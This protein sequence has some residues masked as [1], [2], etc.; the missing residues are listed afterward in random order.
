MKSK[1]VKMKYLPT[2][3]QKETYTLLTAR[4]RYMKKLMRQ[5]VAAPWSSTTTGSARAQHELFELLERV[6][7]SRLDDQRAVLPPYF[8]Q[9]SR[10]E[11]RR[12]VSVGATTGSNVGER[13]SYAEGRVPAPH[14]PPPS[15]GAAAV[16]RRVAAAC[17]ASRLLLEETLAKP[18]TPPTI[19]QPPNGG[20]WVDGVEENSSDEESEQRP[21]PGT[22]RQNS[23]RHNIDTDDTA[24]YYRRFFLGKEHLNLVGCDANLGPVVMSLKNEHVAGQDHTRI[25]LRLRTETM[26]G[27]IPTP[28]SGIMPSPLRMAKMLNDQVN[29]ENF[30]AVM[31]LNAS[32]LIATYDEHVLVNTF[33][34]G[35]LYQKYGQ[36]TEEELF[37]N[38]ETSPAFDEFLEMLGQRIKL[39]DHKGYRGGLD[40]MNGH[41]GTEAVYERFYEREIMF[42]VAPLL[43][44]TAGD[45]QQLQRKRHV[46]N[47]IVAIVFQEKATPFTPDMIASHFLHAFIV[48]T[49]V[50]A[51][52][53]ETR[54]KVAVTARV[55]VPF[56]GP[57]LPQPPIFRK[58]RELKEFLLTKLINAENACYK[59]EK[60]AELEQRT[61]TSL[62]QSLAEKLKEK[63][64]EFLG[65]GARNEAGAVSP[66]PEGTPKQDGPGARFIDTVKK[67]IIS[68]VRSPS[69][70]TNL[71]G[72]SNKN[73]PLNKKINLHE[74]P[75]PNSG[76]S[77]SSIASSSASAVSVRSAGGSG[78]SSPDVT[79]RA[80]PPRPPLHDHSDDS[81][82]NSVD[83][84]PLG[85]VYVDSDTGLESMS[86][87][88]AGANARDQHGGPRDADLLR[89]EVCRLKNDKLDLL[90]QNITWQNEIKCLRER[91]MT[92]QAE[93]ASS[94]K[95]RRH[96][97]QTTTI[98]PNPSTHDSTA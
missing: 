35:V 5:H 10:N 2:G 93:L 4:R 40:I 67:A 76:R 84:D 41:T 50:E 94:A 65:T 29:V 95:E 27:L 79:S 56:F 85:A 26:I 46:G 91:V 13:H 11:N 21:Q 44:H 39:K 33:K 19:V 36:T 23:R 51:A 68:K 69:V 18:G 22:P 43:P 25:L 16:Q 8:S 72:D 57:T 24:K 47:D 55:D 31:C 12:S 7:C 42:H 28:N 71:S 9:V 88:E 15:P 82:L 89:Q 53:G 86:S 78:E 61:R 20:Y 6:Q 52:D 32:S 70:D 1:V 64:V 58:G 37:G 30:M 81:S 59:A 90:K 80:A 75:T 17:Q 48:V 34:F 3:G 49:P 77:K 62:L 14:G 98:I 60:F 87:A 63:T 38:N 54:Y 97:E 96:R 83:L 73:N 92:L 74:T 45:A 66:Q